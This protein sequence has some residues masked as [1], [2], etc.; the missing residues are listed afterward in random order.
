[1]GRVL[2]RGI[3]TVIGLC[4]I[5]FLLSN[6]LAMTSWASNMGDWGFLGTIIGAEAAAVVSLLVVAVLRPSARAVTLSYVLGLGWV[7]AILNLL[8]FGSG[9]Y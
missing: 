2:T 3:A 5:V 6:W 7:L 8:L 9:F 1:M 4:G